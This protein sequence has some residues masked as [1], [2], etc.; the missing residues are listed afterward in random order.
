MDYQLI[1]INNITV[2]GTPAFPKYIASYYDNILQHALIKVTTQDLKVLAG[3]TYNIRAGQEVELLPGT[4]I[5]MGANTEISIG[6][7]AD[8]SN[9]MRVNPNIENDGREL[10]DSEIEWMLNSNKTT[11]NLQQQELYEPTMVY[12]NPAKEIV[13]IDFS[14]AT[15]NQAIFTL[16]DITGR[17]V[18]TEKYTPPTEG[19][20]H[21]SLS[22][23]ELKA[24]TYFYTL[25]VGE[26]SYK[27]K[28][29][30]IE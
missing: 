21:F 24:G 5:Q 1:D 7:C 29:V 16:Y 3:T 17:L 18:K 10:T 20:Q 28:V 11:N 26:Q 15:N 12:P 6:N 13:Y 2:A 9:N 4:D 23:A 8:Y 30:K 19:N 27:G 14:N 22:I 25:Q